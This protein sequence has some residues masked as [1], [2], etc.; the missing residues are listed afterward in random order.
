MEEGTLP[1]EEGVVQNLK[2]WIFDS[3]KINAVVL[4]SAHPIRMGGGQ[5][6]E[7]C[8]IRPLMVLEVTPSGEFL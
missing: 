5:E 2:C 1:P 3:S 4:F 8:Y 6:L 7:L